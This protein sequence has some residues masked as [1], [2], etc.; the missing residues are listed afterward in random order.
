MKATSALACALLAIGVLSISGCAGT[1]QTKELLDADHEPRRS[2]ELLDVPFFS[3][4]EYQCGP[5]ALATVLGSAGAKITPEALVSEVYLPG[6]Q[7]SLQLELLASTRRRGYVPYVLE[8]RLADILDEVSAGS[9]VLVLQNLGLDWH[10]QW[11]YAV[12]VGFDL[13]AG[14]IILRSG[15]EARRVV[16]MDVFERTWERADFWAMVAMPPD[17]LPVTARETSYVSAILALE[18]TK[19]W[20]DVSLA[21]HTALARWPNNL[22]ARIGLGNSLYELGDLPGAE[23]AYRRAA[24][25]HPRA[26]VAFN[27][28]AQA[29]ADQERFPEA[30]EAARRAVRLGGPM[31]DQYR[32]TLEQIVVNSGPLSAPHPGSEMGSR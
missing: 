5:A 19:R 31:Q 3:Q 17:R 12:I 18:R 13:S 15:Q 24:H 25:D 14:N 11:H 7:G 32:D 2:V 28:L 23:A 1:P 9:P 6:R 21:Y 27:N 4:S 10:P 16:S 22:V 20:R 26:A 30:E 29:L 8:P